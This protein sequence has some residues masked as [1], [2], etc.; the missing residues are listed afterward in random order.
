MQVEGTFDVSSDM[1]DGEMPGS[2][3][4]VATPVVKDGKVVS[5][6]LICDYYY[7]IVTDS[8]RVAGCSRPV[9]E[10]DKYPN[11]PNPEPKVA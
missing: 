8:D 6:K 2:V 10:R 5:F 9:D 4:L 1:P 11:W 7:W 3:V